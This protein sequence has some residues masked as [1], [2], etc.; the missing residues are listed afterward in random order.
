VDAGADVVAGGHPHWVQ[1]VELVRGGL[2]A[3]SLGN[4]VFDMDFARETREGAVLEL[5][6][7]GDELKGARLVPVVIGADFAPRPATGPRGAAILGDIWSAS[8]PPLR[9]T[10][11]G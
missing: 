9:G 4:F 10:H 1:G 2:V 8:G 11:A 3:Y 6:F 7:W 5:T